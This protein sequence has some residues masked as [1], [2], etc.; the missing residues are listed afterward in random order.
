MGDEEFPGVFKFNDVM[1]LGGAADL[2]DMQ[3]LQ[4]KLQF[5]DPINIQFTSVSSK[6]YCNILLCTTSQRNTNY[7]DLSP[8]NAHV[9][10]SHW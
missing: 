4:V 1:K 9:N 10:G 6:I 5:D 2:S 8:Q 3:N 7:H